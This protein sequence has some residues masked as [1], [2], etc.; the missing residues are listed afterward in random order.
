M[1][2]TFPPP[3][4]EASCQ[5]LVAA[6]GLVV[7]HGGGDGD[8]VVVVICFFPVAFAHARDDLWHL[9]TRNTVN[10]AK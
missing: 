9:C 5:G 2:S 8:D 3:R 4:R 7:G 1:E 10:S 6:C